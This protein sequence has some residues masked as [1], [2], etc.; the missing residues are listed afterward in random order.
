MNWLDSVHCV[1]LCVCVCA[2]YRCFNF[3][4]LFFSFFLTPT[5][6]LSLMHYITITF[7]CNLPIHSQ[8]SAV[9]LKWIVTIHIHIKPLSCVHTERC[10]VPVYVCVFV[11]ARMWVYI[12]RKNKNDNYIIPHMFIWK[13]QFYSHTYWV[14]HGIIC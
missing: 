9:N 2:F 6:T 1:C 8:W 4:S 14:C 12:K 7:F 11:C 3:D 13:S 10:N 5:R